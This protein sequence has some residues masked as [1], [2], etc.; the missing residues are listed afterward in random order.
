MHDQLSMSPLSH[1]RGSASTDSDTRRDREGA[2]QQRLGVYAAER[3]QR[4]RGASSRA[5]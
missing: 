3:G 5:N 4:A 2:D 1:P